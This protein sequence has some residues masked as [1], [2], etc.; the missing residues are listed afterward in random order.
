[1][2]AGLL[3]TDQPQNAAYLASSGGKRKPTRAATA[4]KDAPPAAPF[5][6]H[7]LD[8]ADA[9]KALEA[10]VGLI[11]PKERA[12]IRRINA[13]A[14]ATEAKLAREAGRV[15]ER[16]KVQAAL[17]RLG[18]AYQDRLLTLGTRLAPKLE[19]VFDTG[20][21]APQIRAVLDAELA[22]AIRALK[23]AAVAEG[24]TTE[25]AMGQTA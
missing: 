24:L 10:L 2:D 18:A 6:F 19:A 25:R 4:S 20:G 21:R 9:G 5:G 15:I 16:S 12:E 3:D 23:Q 22:D 17:G 1:M 7:G 8:P 11:G 13:Q 14:R